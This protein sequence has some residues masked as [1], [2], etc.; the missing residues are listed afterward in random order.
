M[1]EP[2][3]QRQLGCLELST[4]TAITLSPPALICAE[5]NHAGLRAIETYVDG[6]MK[7]L[8][9]ATAPLPVGGSPRNWIRRSANAPIHSCFHINPGTHRTGARSL[10]FRLARASAPSTGSARS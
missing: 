8:T 5:R 7:F 6:S 1:P 3:Y 10:Y 4:L 9:N 2:E